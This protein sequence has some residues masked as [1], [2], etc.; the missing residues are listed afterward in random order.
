MTA[1]LSDPCCPPLEQH[2]HRLRETHKHCLVCFTVITT[3]LAEKIVIITFWIAPLTCSERFFVS[4]NARHPDGAG[5]LEH[6]C[7][8]RTVT[9]KDTSRLYGWSAACMGVQ[10]P[11]WKEPMESAWDGMRWD[12]MK[13]QF[14]DHRI[15]PRRGTKRRPLRC[16]AEPSP[17][18]TNFG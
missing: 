16:D 13:A 18:H 2:N 6:C 9:S 10:L 17:A 5:F 7:R 11:R 15:V 8:T 14:N 4:Y 3:W 12:G 1:H